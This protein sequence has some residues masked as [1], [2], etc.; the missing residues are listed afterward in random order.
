MFRP[1]TIIFWENLVAK[2]Y[3][4]GI[5]FVHVRLSIRMEQLVCHCKDVH[6]VS[7]S[8]IFRKSIEKIKVTIN[9]DKNNGHFT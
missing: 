8:S 2:E 9:S 3:I 7:Y 6:E 5:S 4:Y 1:I